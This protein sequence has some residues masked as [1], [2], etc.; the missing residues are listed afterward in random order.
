MKLIYLIFGGAVLYSLLQPVHSADN[1][2]LWPRRPDELEQARQ[3]MREQKGGE[4]VLLLQPYVA[5]EGIAGREARQICG[6]VN[7]PRY[8][9][10]MHPGAVVY[11]VRKGD[12]M[13]RIAATQ[14]C[15]QDVIMMLNGIVQPSA[16][17]VGQKLVVIPMRLRM[18]IRPLQREVSVWDGEQLVA[19]YPILGMD[20]IPVDKRKTAQ[21]KVAAREGYLNGVAVPL[22][23]PQFAASER[24]LVLSN[25]MCLVGGGNGHAGTLLRMEQKDL[26]ELVMMLDCGNDVRVIYPER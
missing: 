5:D 19:D 13:A 2:S 6:R 21:L 23:S 26:N 10:R 4:A 24:A 18:E 25:G 8:L 17:Q 22:R 16:L 7:V 20:D 1:F 15:P 9:S 14:R 3:L 12:N 11:T